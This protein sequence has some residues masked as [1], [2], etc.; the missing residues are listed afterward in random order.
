MSL[1]GQYLEELSRRYKKQV[2]EMQ[3]SLERATSAMSEE[4]RKGEERDLK[5]MEE[6]AALREEI[7]IL[8]ISLEN[9][10]FDRD[11]W[12]SKLYYFGEHV[13]LICIN[14]IIVSFII[15]YYRRSIDFDDEDREINVFTENNNNNKV[16]RRKPTDFL[17]EKTVLP[18]KPKKRRPSE[19]ANNIAGTYEELM[20]E[21]QRIAVNSRKEKKRKRR[22]ETTFK[23]SNG[24]TKSNIVRYKEVFNCST[25]NLP[26]RRASSNE[27]PSIS[28]QSVNLSDNRPDSAPENY[29]DW[30]SENLSSRIEILSPP[31]EP[32]EEDS[33]IKNEIH[34]VKNVYTVSSNE[35]EPVKRETKTEIFKSKLSSPSFMRT[36][37]RSRSKRFS[38]NDRKSENSDRNKFSSNESNS[39]LRIAT[40]RYLNGSTANGYADESDRS[41]S[42][43]PTS[44]KKEKKS[45][46]L[47]KMVR[48]FF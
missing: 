31:R 6:I 7:K 41:S 46:G 35:N 39:S 45:T 32:S 27:A 4:S 40:D 21:D 2:E 18:K 20:I 22:K 42:A 23:I 44:E 30:V 3:R 9:L 38:G 14:V 34:S 15:S 24:D 11:S 17:R 26:S 13:I 33:S 10:L 48:K 8:S 47:R 25:N 36:A 29:A 43:T 1:S 19:I 12:Q 5:R 28:K 37:L 16:S